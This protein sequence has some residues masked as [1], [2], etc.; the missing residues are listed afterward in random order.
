MK[1]SIISLITLLF[2]AG[3]AY[4]TP[5]TFTD[6][7]H[8]TSTGT[9]AAEDLQG[10]GGS[11]VSGLARAGDYVAWKHF[12]T[13]DPPAAQILQGTLK[14]TLLDDEAEWWDTFEFALGF[15]ENG[16]WA[17]GEVDTGTYHY[18]VNIAAL[19]DGV[20]GVK[21][22]SLGGDFAIT[23]S[24]LTITYEPVPEPSTFLLL[25]A[26]LLGLGY[27]ARKRRNA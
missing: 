21:L 24:E 7:T 16:Q 27:F 4:A 9:E 25:S 5:I 26:G 17:L 1:R 19:E 14:V 18:G 20:F 12:F 13:F 15:A 10:Y 6:T 8:F 22:L 2:L 11:S 23:D 3:A